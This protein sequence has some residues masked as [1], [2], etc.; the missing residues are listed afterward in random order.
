MKAVLILSV[1]K[2]RNITDKNPALSISDEVVTGLHQVPIGGSQWALADC[3]KTTNISL[4]KGHSHEHYFKSLK[5][6][7]TLKTLST[8]LVP[9]KGRYSELGQPK[10]IGIVCRVRHNMRFDSFFNLKMVKVLKGGDT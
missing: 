9:K 4:I 7:N 5:V 8:R 10:N 6:K 1:L 3:D 2:N